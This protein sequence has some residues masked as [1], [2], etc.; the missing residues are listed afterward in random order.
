MTTRPKRILAIQNMEG[1]GFGRFE[2]HLRQDGHDLA[3]LHAY[4]GEPLPPPEA[5]DAV[6]VGGTPLAAYR[7]EEHAFL[8]EEAAFLQRVVAAGTPC[9]GVCFGA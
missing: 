1:E 6:L 9:L 3:V 4:R 5:C 2:R 8:R 7:W